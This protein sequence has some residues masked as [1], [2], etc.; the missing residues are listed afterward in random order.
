MAGRV[1]KAELEAKFRAL[2][3]RP[4]EEQAKEFL[5]S[6]VLDFKG[7]FEEVLELCSNFK[8]FAPKEKEVVTSL[9]EFPAH[10]FLEKRGETLTVAALRENLK[11]EI[12]LEKNHDVAFL[13]YLLWKYHK[14]VNDMFKPKAEVPKEILEALE[15]AIANFEAALA[16]RKAREAK[17]AQLEAAAAA[18]GVKGKAAAN[19]LEQMKKQ[20]QLEQSKREINSAAQQRKAQKAVNDTKRWEE[21]EERKRA[22]AMAS[23]QQRM[24]EEKRR[25]EEEDRNK[26][27]ASRS[28]LK[29][30][31]SLWN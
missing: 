16:V 17:M 9:P 10:L 26:A 1:P 18:G 11:V 8:S 6:F 19:E 23:E 3:Q 13:E 30:K 24:E 31:A 12:T 29:E 21:E 15:K 14:T 27:A 7:N 22:E 5:K 4:V 2:S 20:D 25:K 28:R